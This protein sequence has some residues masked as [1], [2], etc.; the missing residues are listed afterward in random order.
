MKVTLVDVQEYDQNHLLAALEVADEEGNTVRVAHV[1][2]KDAAEWR[3]AEYGL[4]PNDHDT[5]IDVLIHEGHV[6]AAIA[7]EDSLH[8]A[9]TVEHAR[10]ALLGAVRA[11]K[12]KVGPAVA[13]GRVHPEAD[14]RQRMAGMFL[15]HEGVIAAKREYVEHIRKH[16]GPDAPPPS[17]A[18]DR[19]AALRHAVS[20]R[21][22]DATDTND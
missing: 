22:K 11:R 18:D 19:I 12:A 4:D 9:P 16:G 10:E 21:S 8:L 3:V 17:L 13:K 20:M 7:P 6:H 15:M 14:A 2:P 1:M 5:L